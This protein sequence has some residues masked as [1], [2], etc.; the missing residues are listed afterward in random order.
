[1]VSP[2]KNDRIVLVTGATG[3]Q[4][5]AVAKALLR[6]QHRVRAFTRNTDSPRALELKQLGAELV[7]GDFDDGPSLGAALS[8]VDAVFAMGTPFESNA[9]P[10][11][12]VQQ[13][14]RL[15]DFAVAAGIGHFI[16]SS[17]ADANRGTGVP[18][19]DSKYAVERHLVES[20]LPHT[21]IGPS[22]FMENI[23]AL[24]G[25]TLARGKLSVPVPAEKP[26]QQITMIDLGNLVAS[27]I[28]RR[29]TVFGRRIDIASDELTGIEAASIL[30]G[31]LGRKISFESPSLDAFESTI[32]GEAGRD[33]RLMFEYYG[34]IGMHADPSA[35]RVEF[36]EVNWHRFED[37]AKEQDWSKLGGLS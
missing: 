1:M 30:T 11:T 13:G 14:K 5:N 29:E 18:H 15:C 25:Q 21:I 7:R 8:R 9:S 34:S 33:L 31:I 4:G 10:E 19:M 35:L 28:E 20:G 26:L 17:A 37:W 16:Y 22:Y 27:L 6:R 3:Q 23:V 2:T 12:E 24:G 36:A 32:G